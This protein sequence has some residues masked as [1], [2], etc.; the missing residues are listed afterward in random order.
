MIL[1]NKKKMTKYTKAT[2]LKKQ[3]GGRGG[4]T[5]ESLAIKQP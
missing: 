4:K 1:F 2:D 5:I 3:K